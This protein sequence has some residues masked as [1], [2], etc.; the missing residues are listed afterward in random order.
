MLA[1]QRGSMPELI[2]N[3]ETG[4]LV[5]NEDEMVE[6][7]HRV[8]TLDRARC[9]NWVKRRFSVEQMVNG[10]ERLYR[11]A[12]SPRLN[13]VL[14]S[15]RAVMPARKWNLQRLRRREWLLALL[16]P[17][18]C[19]PFLIYFVGSASGKKALKLWLRI[20]AEVQPG[21][22]FFLTLCAPWV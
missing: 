1:Y 22:R 2:K 3:G 5:E 9:R 15:K 7:T 14:K 13:R 12:A 16:H 20:S 18:H 8:E 19:G 21:G 4:Y 17:Y 6:M 11:I 10:Y